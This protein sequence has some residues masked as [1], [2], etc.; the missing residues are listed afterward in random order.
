MMIL[1]LTLSLRKT[2]DNDVLW[3]IG[4]NQSNECNASPLEWYTRTAEFLGFVSLDDV[5]FRATTGE[6]SAA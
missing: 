6:G 1:N 5:P 4:C 3:I 2:D